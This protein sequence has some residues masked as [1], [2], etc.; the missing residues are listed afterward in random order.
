MAAR[1]GITIV[2]VLLAV[3]AFLGGGPTGGGLFDPFGLLWVF[4]AVLIWFGWDKIVRGY[5][6]ARGGEDGAELPL[7][8]RFGPVF[9]TGIT[10]SL[11][12]PKQAAAARS[13]TA[14]K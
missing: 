13:D 11:R 14:G 5:S 3:I 7:L 6:S 12:Q 10:N 1:I 2:A 4:L 8:A 9:I